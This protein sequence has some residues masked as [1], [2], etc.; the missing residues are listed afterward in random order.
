MLQIRREQQVMQAMK[1][2]LQTLTE[3]RCFTGFDVL[4][5]I[6]GIREL[7]S[8]GVPEALA[9]ALY[10]VIEEVH[11]QSNHVS[12]GNLKRQVCVSAQF[13]EFLQ[14]RQTRNEARIERA[15]IDSVATIPDAV[16]MQVKERME[17][18]VLQLPI[19][20]DSVDASDVIFKA[21]FMTCKCSPTEDA[22][23]SEADSYDSF[24][25]TL[26]NLQTAN[27]TDDMKALIRERV[28]VA[29]SISDRYLRRCNELMIFTASGMMVR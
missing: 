22:A 21:A 28:V 4:Y 29:K 14:S 10:D 11:K 5:N 7:T 24:L 20:N 17:R 27:N 15:S 1:P 9:R 3:N 13:E 12:K 23:S 2:F 6:R 25:Q 16:F 18:D 19:T 8:W 26:V